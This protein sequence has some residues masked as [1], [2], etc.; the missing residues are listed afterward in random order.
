MA[1]MVQRLSDAPVP[2]HVCVYVLGSTQPQS[3]ATALLAPLYEINL[4]HTN[5]IRTSSRGG[6][7]GNSHLPGHWCVT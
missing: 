5:L 7:V 6:Y 3:N 2:Q 1:L 4:G